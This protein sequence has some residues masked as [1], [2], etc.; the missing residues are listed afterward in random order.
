MPDDA[1]RAAIPDMVDVDRIVHEPARLAILTTLYPLEESDFVYLH[2]A[3]GLTK[4]NLS[5][6]LSRLESAGYVAI[7]KTY[8]GKVPLTLV[9][10]TH[11]GRAAF[12]AYR[13]RLR[14]IA[15]RLPE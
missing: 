6:H 5:S 1:E 4:G 8:R 12:D 15:A 11:A 2:R 3:T 14:A 9:A 10:M 7:E 13:D